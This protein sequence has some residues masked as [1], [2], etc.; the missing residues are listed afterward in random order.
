MTKNLTRTLIPFVTALVMLQ[1]CAE[2]QPPRNT[3]QHGVIAKED[4]LGKDG[5]AVWYYLQTVVNA[6]YATGF[7][8]A[9]EQSLMDK[10]RWDIQV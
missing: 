9:G 4:L 5:K 10:V 3:V 6:P 8:F 7:T 1:G 2:E